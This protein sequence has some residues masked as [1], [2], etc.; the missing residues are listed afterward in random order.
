MWSNRVLASSLSTVEK[1][2]FR[3]SVFEGKYEHPLTPIP[4]AMR[5][6]LRGR[7]VGSEQ[8]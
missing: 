4:S 3:G 8:R 7:G 2:I 1:T 5:E 6:G